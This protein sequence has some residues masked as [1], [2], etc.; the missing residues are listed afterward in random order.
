MKKCYLFISLL[1]LSLIIRSQNLYIGENA[2]LHIS[3]G[4]SL[5]VGGN[6][7]N[8]GAIQNVGKVSLF[9]NWPVNNNFNGLKGELEFRGSEDQMII[10]PQLTVSKL[11]VNTLGSVDFPGEEY[12]VLDRIEFRFG[13]IAPGDG[14]RFILGENVN[15]IGGSN[16]SY[17][18]GPL[19]SRGSG[20]KIFPVGSKGVYSPMTLLDVFGNDVELEASFTRENPVDPRP[21]DSLLGV[22]HR[23]FWE[24]ELINGVADESQIQLEFNQEDLSDFKIRNDLRHRLN[25]PAIAL[26]TNLTNRWRSLGT[27]EITNSDFLTFGTILG[28]FPISLEVGR[29]LYFAIGLAVKVPEEGLY[30]M[31]EVFSPSAAD[32]DNKSFKIF[33]ERISSQDF[34]LQIYNRLGVQVYSTTSF[35]Q[36]NEDGWDGTNKAGAEEPTGVYFYSLRF[37][38]EQGEVVEESG[39]FYLVR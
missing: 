3:S 35:T 5:E 1:F 33:G 12:I 28:E 6:L 38:F 24:L 32:P 2:L 18:D 37:R 16:D 26:T 10:P 27:R 17:F 31:P 7:W 19:I 14:T 29:M 20:I 36:A 8:A 22:S 30:F 39:A 23:G 4:A 13:T 25:E 21:G 9:S 15:V 11:T 34:H